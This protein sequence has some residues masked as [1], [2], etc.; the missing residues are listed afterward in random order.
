[1]VLALH[2]A[3]HA[4]P[5]ARSHGYIGRAAQP[6]Y[7]IAGMICTEPPFFSCRCAWCMVIYELHDAG[8]AG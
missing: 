5:P 1:M 6:R 3:A 2:S 7:V 8:L 4:E